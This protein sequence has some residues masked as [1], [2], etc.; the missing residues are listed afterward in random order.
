MEGFGGGGR[1]AP[2]M[3]RVDVYVQFENRGATLQQRCE[4]W[5]QNLNTIK[6]YRH[7]QK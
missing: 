5:L 1:E 3:Q 7:K 2:S 4:V 6:E